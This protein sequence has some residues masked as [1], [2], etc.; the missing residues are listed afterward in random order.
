MLEWTCPP[1]PRQGSVLG[2]VGGC[3]TGGPFMCAR[4]NYS[5][6]NSLSRGVPSILVVSHEEKCYSAA[7]SGPAVPRT[8]PLPPGPLAPACRLSGFATAKTTGPPG[9]GVPSPSRR[10]EGHTTGRKGLGAGGGEPQAR[11]GRR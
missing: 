6:I 2:A 10:R 4:A 5:Y 3:V 7:P 9:S 1:W 8:R 11:D